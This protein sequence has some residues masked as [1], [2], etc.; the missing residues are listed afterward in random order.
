MRGNLLKKKILS[1][2]TCIAFALG[3]FLFSANLAKSLLSVDPPGGRGTVNDT[4]ENAFQHPFPD[5][6]REQRREFFVGN[7]FFRDAWVVAKSTTEARDGLG[8]VFNSVSCSGCHALDGR[9]PAFKNGRVHLS[10]LFRL[11]RVGTDGIF[12]DPEYGGQFQPLGI[13]DVEGEG[14][15]A[16]EFRAVKGTFADGTEYEL[17]E[18]IYR[19]ENLSQGPM[20]ARFSP[21]QAPQLAGIGLLEAIREEDILA[22]ADPKDLDQDGISGRPNFVDDLIANTKRIGRFGWKAGQPTLIQQN[23]AAFN[24]DLGITSNLFPKD[25]CTAT[26]TKCLSAPN[27]GDPELSDHILSRVTTYTQLLAVPQRRIHD[28]ES[29]ERGEK[30]FQQIQCAKCHTPSYVTGSDHPIDLLRDQ[31]IYP[32]TDLLL[33]DMGMELADHRPEEGAN[34]REWK[35]P[36]LWGLG[37]L[38]T[39]SKHENLLHDGRARGLEE[40]ILWHGGEASASRDFYK[41]LSLSEREDLLTFLRSI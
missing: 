21:R 15:V 26:Q 11:S 4:T 1:F 31:K 22:Q 19:F 8:P 12:P 20:K 40:A 34:G 30:I 27:G 14:R 16:V 24:G 18:P 3:I 6:S 33:H 38:Q 28:P 17:R 13:K 5:V 9:G 36:P 23:A 35:T 7:S 10:L 29:V 39:V 32:Y 37:L 2:Y 41:K 25:D